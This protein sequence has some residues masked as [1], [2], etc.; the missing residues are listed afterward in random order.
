[1]YMNW[2]VL[3]HDQTPHN[4]STY[5]YKVAQSGDQIAQAKHVLLQHKPFYTNALFTAGLLHIGYRGLRLR[6]A[7]HNVT[8]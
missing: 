7:L 8:Y 1:M 6:V 4:L 5:L 2:S 3:H